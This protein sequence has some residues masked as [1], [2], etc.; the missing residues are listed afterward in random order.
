MCRKG[1]E[2]DMQKTNAIRWEVKE[3]RCSSSLA[4][5]IFK[6]KCTH[7]IWIR[8]E[9]VVRRD[10]SLWAMATARQIPRFVLHDFQQYLTLMR[11]AFPYRSIDFFRQKWEYHTWKAR[12]GLNRLPETYF[13][14]LERVVPLIQHA[15]CLKSL[16]ASA[17]DP[18]SLR[19]NILQD[20]ISINPSHF[21]PTW[22][23]QS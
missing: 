7:G 13:H 6:G 21:M 8:R 5:F 12:Q 17:I 20:T 11:L 15:V 1:L 18:R 19:T 9:V 4:V 16:F 2:P 10:A 14:A 3:Q 22:K 23:S